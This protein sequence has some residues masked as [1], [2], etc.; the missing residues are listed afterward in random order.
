MKNPKPKHLWGQGGFPHP[1]KGFVV[2]RRMVRFG[3]GTDVQQ[4][5]TCKRC[6]LW[7]EKNK[8]PT[9]VEKKS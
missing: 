9:S 7:I 5:V 1:F 6:L 3:G 8:S 4:E 2:C